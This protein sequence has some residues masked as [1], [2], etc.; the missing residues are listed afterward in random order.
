MSVSVVFEVD[1]VVDVDVDQLRV[2]A[3]TAAAEFVDGRDSIDVELTVRLARDALL[4][5]LN[6]EHRGIDE[7]TD[8]LSFPAI[9]DEFPDD[10]EDATYLGDVAISF[11]AA[12]RNVELTG[13]P[14]DREL[15]HLVTHGV[16]HLLGY[17]HGSTEDTAAMRAREV[18]LLGDWVHAIWDAPP[19]H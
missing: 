5:R 6:R 13:M 3:E 9:D 17:D 18:E 1:E 12:Q 7:P 16:L 10:P 4:W 2:A 14:L 15:R 8:V 19:T 11:P